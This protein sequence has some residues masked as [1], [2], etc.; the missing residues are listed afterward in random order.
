[1]ALK[2]HPD[3]NPDNENAKQKFEEIQEAYEVL[4]DEK[5]RKIYDKFGYKGLKEYEEHNF[6]NQQNQEKEQ[7]VKHID[8]TIQDVMGD[9][10]YNKP[11]LV[12]VTESQTSNERKKKIF[13][14]IDQLLQQTGKIGEYDQK[15]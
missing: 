8:Y 13:E 5:K 12:I 9:K 7:T 2:Y 3:K 14:F 6:G 15:I 1:M 4:S 10:D 11:S